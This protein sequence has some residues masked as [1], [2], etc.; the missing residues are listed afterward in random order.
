[1]SGSGSSKTTTFL[2]GVSVTT[3]FTGLS[4]VLGLVYFSA[5]SRLLTKEDFGYFAALTGIMAVVGVFSE[6]GIG[7]SIIQKKDPTK[8]FV[9]TAFTMSFLL[10][11][12]CFAIVFTFA[13]F[14]ANLIADD[15]LTLPL[16][17]MAVGLLLSPFVSVGRAQ[18]Y[19]NLKFS[20][21]GAINLSSSLM[22]V[23]TSV[24]LAYQGFGVYSMIAYA[25]AA[26]IVTC[27]IFVLTGVKYPKISIEKE[28]VKGI[29][30]FGGW[31]TL[32]DMFNK[33]ASLVDRLLLPKLTSIKILGEYTR[34]SSF[35]F[36][37][38]G[39]VSDVIDRV[40]F[41]M[42][43][44][45][46]DEKEATRQVF[47]RAIELLNIFSIIMA[48]AFFFNADLIIRIFFGS[49]WMSLSVVLQILSVTMIFQIDNQLV[50]C[51]FRSLN[52][53]RTGFYL[54]ALSLVLN[55]VAIVIGSK[56]NV[57]G[58][59]AAVAI[60]NITVILLRIIVLGVKIEA[61]NK[62]IIGRWFN[63]WKPAVLPILVGVVF[64]MLPNTLIL[65]II[66]ASIMVVII[67][68]E[69][70]LFP[71]FVGEE[72]ENIAKPILN[73]IRIRSIY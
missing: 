24:L 10:A 53:V 28:Q 60:A 64:I 45:T 39:Q 31:L 8:G 3:L 36:N 26:N 46:Q 54:R 13:P 35:V 66:C 65:N 6:G 12:I 25:I 40:L 33:M 72:Y 27:L 68:A 67:I 43:S 56:Y 55:F 57:V 71:K 17:V 48:V 50:D 69:L 20:K 47:Y 16:R 59:A 32:S 19:R 73:K 29:V 61:S 9:S 21:I 70:V 37:I 18:L 49:E 22:A 2:K 58:I 4:G 14:I 41:P 44:Q 63:A 34:P 51:F 52:L 62:T 11:L 7:A 23:L 38:S 42:L 15:Y 5:M 1:M 30:N